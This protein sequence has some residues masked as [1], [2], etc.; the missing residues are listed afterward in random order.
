MMNDCTTGI[1]LSRDEIQQNYRSADTLGDVIEIIE[2]EYW[3]KGQVLCEIRVNDMY[4]SE[5]DEGSFSGSKIDEV[6]KLFFRTQNVDQLYQESLISILDIIPRIGKESIDVSDLIRNGEI[7]S[8]T[9]SLTEIFDSSHW[10]SN[11]LNLLKPVIFKRT[12]DENLSDEWSSCERVFESLIREILGAIEKKDYSL[13]SDLLEYEMA[14]ILEK[15]LVILDGQDKM[16]M[17]AMT[18]SDSE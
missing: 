1:S 15:W 12:Q 5:E 9:T 18:E 7:K 4:L 11:A 3:K 13:L 16:F 8:A 2:K 14:G 10:L 6:S 17:P